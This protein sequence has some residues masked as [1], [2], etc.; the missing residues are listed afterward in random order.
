[1]KHVQWLTGLLAAL[2]AF[3]NTGPSHAE[4]KNMNMIKILL[5]TTEQSQYAETA[6]ADILSTF[7]AAVLG[8]LFKIGPSFQLR[9]NLVESWHWDY[10]TKTYE[11]TLRRD[12]M[13]H[14]GRQATAADLEYS[15][16]RGFFSSERSFYRLYLGNIEGLDAAAG[17]TTFRS[18]L[19]SGVQVT[20]PH[21]VRIKLHTPNPAFLHSL[22]DGYFSL[23]PREAI[24]DD[25][26]TWRD[27]PVGSG[28]FRVTQAFH[29]GRVVVEQ[30]A[31]PHRQIT[32]Y[33]KDSEQRYDVSL[34]DPPH[35]VTGEYQTHLLNLPASVWTMRFSNQH[36]LAQNEHFRRAV[37]YLVNQEALAA[38]LSGCR[39]TVEMLPHHFWGRA[40]LAGRHD[41]KRAR[42]E[43]ALV[44][45]SLKA[46]PVEI[47]VFSGAQM[48]RYRAEILRRLETQF[49]AVGLQ[50]RISTSRD[51][52]FDDE[53]AKKYA[54]RISGIVTDY[55]DPLVM[56]SGFSHDSPYKN[57]RPMGDSAFDRLYSEAVGIEAQDQKIEAVKIISRLVAESPI[58]IPLVEENQ[59][60]HYR[61]ACVE[62]LGD[63]HQP[64]TLVVENIRFR[65]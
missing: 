7:N 19:V 54:I 55:V 49:R 59:V 62:S 27:K 33:T 31:A 28:P 40:H 58:A 45:D 14:N 63:Q 10:K 42:E 39:P 35:Q 1:M 50:L 6:P 23:V 34:V 64:L 53:S 25:N 2:S 22:V 21:T 65:N 17:Q 36:P 44:P 32:F 20:G 46:A 24:N 29:D 57:L 61:N 11:L 60:I 12:I 26:T 56:F 18:G 51:K 3:L 48:P 37:S 5:G 41:L 8:S 43:L 16:L 47:S 13:F 4:P 52:F 9:A 15:L 38:G 30:V